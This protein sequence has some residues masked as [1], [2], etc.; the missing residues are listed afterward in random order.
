MRQRS[1]EF[2][3][4]KRPQI[5]ARTRLAQNEAIATLTPLELLDAYWKTNHIEPDEAAALNALAAE[6]INEPAEPENQ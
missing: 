3:L 1:F 4:V 6:L 5:A 2:H